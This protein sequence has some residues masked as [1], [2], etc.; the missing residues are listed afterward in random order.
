MSHDKP[1]E[2]RSRRRDT[3]QHPAFMVVYFFIALAFFLSH[4]SLFSRLLA[5]A[6]MVALGVQFASFLWNR[7]RRR[8]KS[9][10]PPAS[11]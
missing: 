9:I 6:M 8:T 10:D 1:I 11:A 3:V 2:E 5:G 7:R 4:E